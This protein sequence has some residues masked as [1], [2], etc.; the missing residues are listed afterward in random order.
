MR[1]TTATRVPV[2]KS[3]VL[4]NGNNYSKKSGYLL[5]N[6][7][8][9]LQLII[10]ILQFPLVDIATRRDNSSIYLLKCARVTF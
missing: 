2:S 5:V 10:Y 8:L 1:H 3:D 6:D 7:S 4:I 9:I